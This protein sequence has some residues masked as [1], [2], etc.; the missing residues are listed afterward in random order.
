MQLLQDQYCEP[1]FTL[2]CNV[3]VQ[4][5]ASQINILLEVYMAGDILDSN[6]GDTQ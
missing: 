4:E 6:Q 5:V 3:G 2:N 1:L